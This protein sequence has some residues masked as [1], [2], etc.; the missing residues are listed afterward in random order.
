MHRAFQALL[1]WENRCNPDEKVTGHLRMVKNPRQ[2]T[3]E[4]I[5]KHAC[6]Q[7]ATL[8]IG[9]RAL[10]HCDSMSRYSARI[11][12]TQACAGNVVPV[13]HLVNRLLQKRGLW[14]QYE[15]SVAH[16]WAS[17]R[18][19]QTAPKGYARLWI[20]S[21]FT[22]PIARTPKCWKGKWNRQRLLRSH[23]CNIHVFSIHQ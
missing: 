4:K 23:G 6:G 11:Q 5:Q 1:K 2:N 16:W 13:V 3:V 17:W 18:I 15:V 14:A 22:D 9:K 10:K 7:G 12:R 8:S 20:W 19:K 21:V